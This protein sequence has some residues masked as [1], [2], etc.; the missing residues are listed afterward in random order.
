MKKYGL[1]TKGKPL[2][3]LNKIQSESLEEA[4]E[5]FAKIKR[6]P[7]KNLIEI[8]DVKEITK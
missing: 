2:E 7:K 5:I 3:I 4:I 1:Y 6:I 8:W